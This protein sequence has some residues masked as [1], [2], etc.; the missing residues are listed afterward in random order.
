MTQRIYTHL[1][2]VGVHNAYNLAFKKRHGSSAKALAMCHSDD[3]DPQVPAPPLPGNPLPVLRPNFLLRFNHDYNQY[4]SERVDK[5]MIEQ[6]CAH[7]SEKVIN[8]NTPGNI[9]Y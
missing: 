3:E 5:E 1:A 4:V 2:Q 6:I 7:T 8:I 9:I